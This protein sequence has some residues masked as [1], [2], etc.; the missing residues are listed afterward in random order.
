MKK[1]LLIAFLTVAT[2]FANLVIA[3]E[4]GE[5][6]VYD[7]DST[8]VY[9]AD[10]NIYVVENLGENINTDHV[11]SGPRISPDGKMLYFFMIEYVDNPYKEEYPDVKKWPKRSIY[12]SE[13][14][15][16]DS[17][18]SKAE[19]APKPLNN[20]GDNSV[21]S[22]SPDGKTLLLHNIYLKNGLTDDGL[23]ISKLVGKK[24]SDPEAVKIK[25]FKNDTVCSFFLSEDNEYL[26][27]AI[28][29]K[30]SLGMQ[31]LYVSFLQEDGVHYGEPM[32][33][34]PVVNSKY[35]EATAF[36]ASDHKTLYFSS[37]KKGGLG[38]YDIYK[39]V[40]KDSTWL[41]WSRPVNLKAPW[42]TH[43]DEFY[44][45]IPTDGE[46][47]YLAHHFQ[48]HDGKEHSDIVRIR[49]KEEWKPRVYIATVRLFDEG[50]KERISGDVTFLEKKKDSL[51]GVYSLTDTTTF[52]V[53]LPIPDIYEYIAASPGYDTLH[54][55]LNLSKM[56]RYKEDTLD[57]YLKRIPIL[58]V[59]GKV[60]DEFTHKPIVARIIFEKMPVGLIADKDLAADEPYMV[61][62]PGGQKY[63]YTVESP[64]YFPEISN[65]DLTRLMQDE[66]RTIDVF[67]KPLEG[68]KF[69][70]ENIFFDTGKWD[71][72]PASNEELDK[73]VAQMK[74]IKSRITVEISGHT[75]A[76]GSEKNNQKLSENRAKSVVQYLVKSGIEA[77]TLKAK[78]YGEIKPKDTNDTP[79]GRQNNR[80]VEFEVLSVGS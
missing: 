23:S 2:V 16:K 44:F 11:E 6:W 49:M 51:M 56:T 43:D 69:E 34:G 10:S 65:L 78:G 8:I 19:K 35:S 71:L 62:L 47:S 46:Y 70:V 21:H 37:N 67:L 79:E 73:L 75:D 58:T 15:E 13:F 52:T 60:Y 25:H 30:E 57:I 40:R 41:K 50:T 24:W 27:L 63:K 4:K 54:N 28:R 61:E 33:L 22:I 31:D 74:R 38:G 32:N 5:H 39:T 59:I 14:N 64:G 20:M 26:L 68:L 9:D 80:R 7:S 76:V 12:F 42:N 53:T 18:W 36:L 3:Q 45:S 17:S 1:G 29:N 55:E 77:S 66:E 48:T 72:L